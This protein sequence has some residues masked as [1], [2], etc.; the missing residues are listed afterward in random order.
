MS[1]R[2]TCTSEQV[3]TLPRSSHGMLGPSDP[4][5]LSAPGQTENFPERRCVA[6]SWPNVFLIPGTQ[7]PQQLT[8]PHP[9]EFESRLPPSSSCLV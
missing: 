9:L 7:G 1:Q 6:M 2:S 4:T 3:S 5:R 8:I